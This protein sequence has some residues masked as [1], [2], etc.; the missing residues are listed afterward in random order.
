MKPW[1]SYLALSLLCDANFQL[2]VSKHA[3]GWHIWAQLIEMMALGFW[4]A[5]FFV[6]AMFL[7]FKK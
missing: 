5:A 6:K 1:Q 4:G 7:Y 3:E 2:I